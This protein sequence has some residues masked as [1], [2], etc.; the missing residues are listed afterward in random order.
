LSALIRAKRSCKYEREKTTAYKDA[1]TAGEPKYGRNM[2]LPRGQRKKRVQHSD[3]G[4]KLAPN[5]KQEIK[6]EK[7]RQTCA[8]QRAKQRLRKLSSAK[9]AWWKR[10]LTG[11]AVRREL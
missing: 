1:Q 3:E 8:K 5:R 6:T 4:V 7:W 9:D 11:L 2:W 10:A